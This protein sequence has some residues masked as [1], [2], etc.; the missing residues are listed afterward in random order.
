MSR[1]K[2]ERKTNRHIGSNVGIIP[3]CNGE[4]GAVLKVKA[5]DLSV[6]LRFNPPP[7]AVTFGWSLKKLDHRFKQPQWVSLSE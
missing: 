4:E 6:H 1:G 5:L 7:V 2:M 3:Y